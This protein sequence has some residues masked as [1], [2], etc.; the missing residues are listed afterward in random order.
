MPYSN[1]PS[2]FDPSIRP[3][4]RTPYFFFNSGATCSPIQLAATR[5]LTGIVFFGVVEAGLAIDDDGGHEIGIL[6]GRIEHLCFRNSLSKTGQ[7]VTCKTYLATWH[8]TMRSAKLIWKRWC[9]LVY[10]NLEIQYT[11]KHN[12]ANCARSYII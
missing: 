3:V 9:L 6:S 11:N 7:L 4:T 10:L 12:A 1:H 2:R 5:R 8:F